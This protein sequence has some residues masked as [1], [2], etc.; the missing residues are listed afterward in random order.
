MSGSEVESKIE[1]LCE[2]LVFADADDKD[3]LTDVHQKL[4]ELS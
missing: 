4:R 1:E 3:G 2:A